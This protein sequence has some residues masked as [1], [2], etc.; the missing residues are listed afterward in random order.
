MKKTGF[1]RSASAAAILGLTLTMGGVT[2]AAQD[3]PHFPIIG[4]NE[5]VT[6]TIDKRLNP[7]SIGG[8][9][10]G[11]ADPDATGN[12]LQGATFTGTLLNVDNVPSADLGRLNA[13]NYEDLGAKLIPGTSVSG[14]TDS[15]GKLVFRS[16]NSDLQQGI[17]FFEE[18]IDGPVT[19]VDTGKTYQPGEVA[20][21][22]PFVVTLPYTNPTGNGWNRDVVVQPK[23]TTTDVTKEVKDANKNVGD[24][25]TYVVKGGVPVIPTGEQ[26]QGF[27]ITDKLDV[28]NLSDIAVTVS[29][30]NG[31][32]LSTADYDLNIDRTTGQIE[33][34]FTNLATLAGRASGTTIDLNITAKVKALEGTDGVAVN[35]AQQFVHYPNQKNEKK[36]ES[37]E[38]KS[39]W[40]VVN[41]VKTEQG[42]DTGL[43]GAEFEL[44]RCEGA[45]SKDAL[46]AETNN[47][48]KISIGDVSTWRTGEDGKVLIDGLHV[49]DIENNSGQIDKTY[50]LVE[51]KA[52]RGYVATTEVYTFKL[53][54]TQERSE[55][56]LIS[57]DAKIENTR[58]EMPQL[59]L[60][61]GMGIGLLAALAALVAGLAAWFARRASSKA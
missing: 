55:G 11:V 42:T 23:N 13:T 33:V 10:K 51:T 53:A 24:T 52:P 26:L 56:T 21:S 47:G 12:R 7:T 4:E 6:L 40:G 22:S 14:K 20:E 36:T 28:E 5:R 38:V 48:N 2:A 59:P 25:I 27:R 57:H 9:G 39:Y 16:D 43:E 32:E 44:Y 45:E 29:A 8:P 19:D 31:P 54:S 15:E 46:Q 60:T 35:Q 49:T 34:K 1:I 18:T 3:N 37:N 17:W 50:C 58:S 41:V 61:G 30:S